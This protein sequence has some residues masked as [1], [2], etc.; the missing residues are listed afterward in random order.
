[1]GPCHPD[2]FTYSLHRNQ[3]W[4]LRAPR[5][6]P[7][8]SPYIFHALE[9]SLAGQIM[10]IT[11]CMTLTYDLTG[12]TPLPPLLKHRALQSHDIQWRRPGDPTWTP[13]TALQLPGPAPMFTPE[14][15]PSSRGITPCWFSVCSRG[16]DSPSYPGVCFSLCTTSGLLATHC[17]GAVKRVWGGGG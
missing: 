4:S 12:I 8:P 6:L 5:S 17:R 10:S 7:L 1:M 11:K 3:S 16:A 9:R 2:L 13:S 15:S 14:E